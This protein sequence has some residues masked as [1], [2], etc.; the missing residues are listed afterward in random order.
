MRSERN[1]YFQKEMEST[2]RDRTLSED[3]WVLIRANALGKGKISIFFQH[4]W[5]NIL[6][7]CYL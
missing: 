7:D 2:S 1:D 6:V 5:V 3:V 4:L